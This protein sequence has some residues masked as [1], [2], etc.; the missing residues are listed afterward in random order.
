LDPLDQISQQQP[1]IP[2]TTEEPPANR[3]DEA[4]VGL[5]DVLLI[6]LV[7]V[8]SFFF[9]VV[10]AS[11]ALYIY[12]RVHGGDFKEL[13]NS[14]AFA[15]PLQVTLYLIVI[16]FMALLVWQRYQMRLLEAIYWRPPH[17]QLAWAAI[18][19]GAGLAVMS[20]V[21]SGALQQWIPKS[22]PIDQ[23]FRTPASAWILALFG[24][25]VAPLVEEIFFRGFVYPALARYTGP[26]I[27]IVLTA[28][29]FA[30]I[31]AVQLAHAWAPLLILFTVGAVLTTVRAKTKS[32]AVCVLMHMAY[33]TILFTALFIQTGG[34]RHM[35]RAS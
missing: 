31:H 12:I 8:L 29:G 2:S 33:N 11:F 6:L 17:R 15:I 30:L 35:E 24:I 21:L 10:V 18:A 22:L 3:D 28:A 1:D 23:F 4:R 20:Q 32:V 9:C 26:L 13:A 16:G 25:L 34:F 19:G 7:T 27:S 5:I 14:A